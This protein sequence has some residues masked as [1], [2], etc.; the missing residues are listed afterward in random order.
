MANTSKNI[1]LYPVKVAKP[2]PGHHGMPPIMGKTRPAGRRPLKRGAVSGVWKTKAPVRKLNTAGRK[3]KTG[4]P[5]THYNLTL[6][7]SHL[8]TI[9]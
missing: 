6:N 7:P 8:W 1:M 9:P 4:K 2:H 5:T 3:I